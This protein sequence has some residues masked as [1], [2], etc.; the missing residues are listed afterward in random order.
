VEKEVYDLAGDL[1]ALITD[2][3]GPDAE[4]HGVELFDVQIAGARHAP[5]VRVFL[6][7]ADGIGMDDI[8][9]A[10]KRISTLLDEQ[11]LFGGRYTLEVSSPGV[12]RPLR[13]LD[14]VA[15]HLSEKAQVTLVEAVA[16]RKRF[17][18]TIVRVADGAMV[19]SADDTGEVELPWV[20]VAKANL[21]GDIDLTRCANDNR[22]SEEGTDHL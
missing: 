2:I 4:A 21:K 1:K 13:N 12:D 17:T 11:D 20:I 6:D 9:Q 18:G 15:A 16:G 10:T 22:I 7:R 5:V 19:L 14:D 3:I 8:A